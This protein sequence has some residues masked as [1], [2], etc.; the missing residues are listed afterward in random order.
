MN[1]EI[2]WGRGGKCFFPNKDQGT[3]VGDYLGTGK[4]FPSK[5]RS[6]E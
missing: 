3:R 5:E 1:A 6:S 2:E 4:Y